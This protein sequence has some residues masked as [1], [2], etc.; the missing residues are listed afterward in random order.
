MK[1]GLFT[2]ILILF[3]TSTYAQVT[4]KPGVRLGL[5]IASIS[6][7]DDGSK[8]DLHAGIFGELRLGGVYA[9]QP[10]INYSK[11]GSEHIDFNYLSIRIVNK[12][13]ILSEDT[14][15]FISVSPGFDVN[16]NGNTQSYSNEYGAGVNFDADLSFTGGIG[17]DFPFGLGV[18]ARYKKGIIDIF[19]NFDNQTKK[20]LNS[21]IQL[22]AYYKFDFG[23]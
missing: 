2:I 23:R 7:T 15:L 10:E 16:L 6:N 12:F 17:Y 18:E 3:L 8:I 20:R 13:Y 14:P 19:T 21:V 9:L 11:Q 1:K 4:F 5:N 22:S